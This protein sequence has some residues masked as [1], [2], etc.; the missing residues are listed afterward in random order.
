M[1]L[2]L[3]CFPTDS[4][5]S[6][7]WI[8]I[9]SEFYLSVVF[10]DISSIFIPIIFMNDCISS[11]FRCCNFVCS[12]SIPSKYWWIFWICWSFASFRKIISWSC[13]WS[14]CLTMFSIQV[15]LFWLSYW[16]SVS[17]SF[18]TLSRWAASSLASIRIKSTLFLFSLKLFA[19]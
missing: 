3:T 12:S 11:I 13:S 9:E 14:S 16:N 6:Y 18:L 8:I 15:L 10:W 4:L 7:Y 5:L 19:F 2:N 17:S 1:S